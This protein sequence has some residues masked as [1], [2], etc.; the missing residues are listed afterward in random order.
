MSQHFDP[1]P[2]DAGRAREELVL[3]RQRQDE[4]L[5]DF[6]RRIQDK[7]GECDFNSEQERDERIKEAL[8]AGL[9]DRDLRCRVKESLS[10]RRNSFMEILDFASHIENV[11]REEMDRDKRVSQPLT[12]I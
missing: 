5:T 6:S 10:F 8:I 7:S 11:R 2:I 4:R 9:L 12:N 1:F 3:L